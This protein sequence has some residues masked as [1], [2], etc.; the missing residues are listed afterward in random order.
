TCIV[1]STRCIS[2]YTLPAI[3]GAAVQHKVVI[4]IKVCEPDPQVRLFHNRAQLLLYGSEYVRVANGILGDKFVFDCRQHFLLRH[5]REAHDE[6]TAKFEVIRA[7][8]LEQEVEVVNLFSKE[9]ENVRIDWL[10]LAFGNNITESVVDLDFI[11]LFQSRLPIRNGDQHWPVVVEV[12]LVK[13]LQDLQACLEGGG[14]GVFS[15]RDIYTDVLVQIPSRQEFLEGRSTVK[16][17]S[18]KGYHSCGEIGASHGIGKRRAQHKLHQVLI[19]AGYPVLP[20]GL[21]KRGVCDSF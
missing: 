12:G 9:F 4:G 15:T 20:K 2:R 6:E 14:N 5:I 8:V 21:L 19:F 16:G 17:H 13:L 3:A 18:G 1:T 7:Y 11:N 10:R